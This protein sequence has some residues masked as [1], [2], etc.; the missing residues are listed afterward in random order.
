MGVR[1]NPI[2][3][4]CSYYRGGKYLWHVYEGGVKNPEGYLRILNTHSML[5]FGD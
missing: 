4:L 1:S 3:Q 2:H 5:K